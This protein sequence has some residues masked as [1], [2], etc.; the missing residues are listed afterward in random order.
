MRGK[1]INGQKN[2][3]KNFGKNCFRP[4]SESLLINII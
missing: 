1:D 3:H 2:K 4:K